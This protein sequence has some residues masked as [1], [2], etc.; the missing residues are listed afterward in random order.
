MEWPAAQLGQ[1]PGVR[2]PVI[3]HSLPLG[4]CPPAILEPQGLI[5]TDS[6]IPLELPGADICTIL[7]AIIGNMIFAKVKSM[8]HAKRSPDTHKKC[9]K[10]KKN[11]KKKSMPTAAEVINY[12]FNEGT[13][14][15]VHL[16]GPDMGL[17]K[18]CPK[19]GQ[20]VFHCPQDTRDRSLCI[21]RP[22]QHIVNFQ[23]M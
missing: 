17:V 12:L 6:V 13:L 23:R 1:G 16:E 19:G 21:H 20:K 15:I 22:L 4:R 5:T 10:E 7:S 3:T 14:A 8:P 18:L 9:K 11:A 2:G